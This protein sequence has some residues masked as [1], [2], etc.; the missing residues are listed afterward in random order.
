MEVEISVNMVDEEPFK[1]LMN[2]KIDNSNEFATLIEVLAREW[3]FVTI[4]KTSI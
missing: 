1:F 3:D 2:Y 4:S